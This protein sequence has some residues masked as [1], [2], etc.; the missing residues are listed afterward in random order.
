MK[1]I[2]YLVIFTFVI[3]GLAFSQADLQPVAVVNLTKSE[4]I[5]VK[6]FRT[7]VDRMAK[8]AG[9]ALTATEQRQVLDVMINEKLAM[10]AAEQDKI[11]VSDSEVN[12]QLQALRNNLA[13][14]LGRNPTDAEF[15]QAVMNDTGLD[16]PAFRDQLKK[17]IT[18]QKYIMDKKK[19]LLTNI[20]DPTD[21]EVTDAYN[22]YKSQFVRPDTVRFSMIQIPFTDDASK[23]KAKVIA[24]RLSQ[25]IGT[26]PAK[27][28]D[29]LLK[30]QVPNAEYQA[31]D[32][33]YLPRNPQAVQMV[34]AD[35]INM[36]FSLKQGEVSK[37]IE[38]ARSYQMIKITE[39]Y[40]QKTLELDD[41]F[42]LAS[43]TTVRDYIKSSLL[44]Q[45][46]QAAIDQASQ[47]IVTEL[48]TGNPF[49]II[50]A[51]LNL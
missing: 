6:Q 16:L 17:Q 47:E 21:Q 12:Q 26:D 41:I 22:L 1:K 36:A 11:T 18:M 2:L 7:E 34:G 39:A 46:Q 23:A 25:T 20:P 45:R 32:A 27:F 19:D 13:Q 50:E 8:Q 14:S 42:D 29:A 48:R 37:M 51:N 49:Q 43:R 40:T 30:G 35:F 10:Q 24:D 5:T 38:S 31:G 28:D 44:G 3:S 4:P 33:G 15:S 9:R